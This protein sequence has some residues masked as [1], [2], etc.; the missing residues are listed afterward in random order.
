MAT[1]RDFI[2]TSLRNISVLGVG[3][4]LDDIEAA[5]ALEMLND[6]IASWSAEGNMVYDTTVETFSLVSGTEA[7]TIGSAG[8]F[9]TTRP[10]SITAAYVTIAGT[11]YPL[12]VYGA[13]QYSE[14]SDKDNTGTPRVFWY[15]DNHT[16]GNIRIYPAPNT[17]STITLYSE[18]ALTEF[19][20]LDTVYAMPAE[21]KAAIKSNLSVWIA[22]QYEREAPPTIQRMARETKKVVAKQNRKAKQY[23]KSSNVPENRRDFSILRGYV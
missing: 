10:V 8:D 14:I 23:V 19:S 21:D 11:D 1:A 7:Y 13:K 6:M 18:K 3:S 16:L 20:T 12:T 22:P 9:A 17:T 15:D 5:D 2:K 4:S